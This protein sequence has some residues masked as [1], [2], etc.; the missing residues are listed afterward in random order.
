MFSFRSERHFSDSDRK[1]NGEMIHNQLGCV[2]CV[3]DN[4]FKQSVRMAVTH[5]LTR[6]DFLI[7]AFTDSRGYVHTS[8]SF[9]K[10]FFPPFQLRES[11]SW[12][13]ERR[14]ESEMSTEK[15]S[16]RE[17]ENKPHL[18][19]AEAQG[20]NTSPTPSRRPFSVLRSLLNVK[21]SVEAR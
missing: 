17:R 14:V 9:S 19:W 20:E 16:G 10:H 7:H 11:K 1:K 8:Y 12:G 13:K 18:C 2:I 5:T 21:P 4:G 15:I 6:P 3:P